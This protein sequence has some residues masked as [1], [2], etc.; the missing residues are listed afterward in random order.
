VLIFDSDH[1]QKPSTAALQRSLGLSAAEAELSALL[2]QG[3][4]LE[5]A[6]TRRGLSIHT[7]RS[8]LKVIFGKTGA[9]SQAQLVRMVLTGPASVSGVHTAK[10]QMPGTAVRKLDSPVWG[11]RRGQGRRYLTRTSRR[12]C[13]AGGL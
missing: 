1:L 11:M 6:A 10:L 5:D 4:S 12:K 9:S 2:A 13:A 7:V 3:L 8:Q